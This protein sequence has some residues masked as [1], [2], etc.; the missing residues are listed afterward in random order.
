M[1][2][3]DQRMVGNQVEFLQRIRGHKDRI[4]QVVKIS[5][6]NEIKEER[7]NCYNIP[8]NYHSYT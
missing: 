2:S 4:V 1:L 3:N 6:W 8:T 7:M 5:K